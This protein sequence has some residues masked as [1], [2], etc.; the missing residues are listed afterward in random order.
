MT[1][2]VVGIKPHKNIHGLKT[3]VEDLVDEFIHAYVAGIQSRLWEVRME[4]CGPSSMDAQIDQVGV[5]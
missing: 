4:R 1:E 3:T 5:L 2:N